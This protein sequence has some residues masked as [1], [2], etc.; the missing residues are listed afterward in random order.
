MCRIGEHDRA[1]I[2]TTDPLEL[3]RSHPPGFAVTNLCVQHLDGGAGGF[4]NK[5]R[6]VMA[7]IQLTGLTATDAEKA[8][9][10]IWYVLEQRDIESPRVETRRDRGDRVDI[11]VTFG[12]Q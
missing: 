6:G 11:R 4:G 9:A 1:P 7:V 10:H 12:S 2:G 5:K 8:I 3:R